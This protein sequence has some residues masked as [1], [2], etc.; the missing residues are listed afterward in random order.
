MSEI[1]Q[2][3]DHLTKVEKAKVETVEVTVGEGDAERTVPAKRTIIRGITVTVLDEAID[4]FELLDDLRAVD[5]DGNAAHLPALLRRL[6]GDEYKTVMD[7]LRDKDT[8]RVSIESGSMFVKE[9]FGALNP[10]S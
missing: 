9:I 6:V 7:G 5:V 3:Q 8:G 1:K 4:D 2:P 10:N